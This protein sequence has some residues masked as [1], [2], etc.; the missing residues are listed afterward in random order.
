MSVYTRLHYK[1]LTDL[2]EFMA[3]LSTVAIAVDLY[4]CVSDFI[5]QHHAGR[6][7]PMIVGLSLTL[8][9]MCFAVGKYHVKLVTQIAKDLKLEKVIRK[10]QE[11][12]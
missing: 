4:W 12:Q 3:I 1:A 8:I 11:N 6:L 7:V 2:V 10:H 9:G 5:D